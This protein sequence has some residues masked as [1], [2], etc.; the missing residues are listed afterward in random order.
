[1]RRGTTAAWAFALVGAWLASGR[2]AWTAEALSDRIEVRG[3]VTR[4]V[5]GGPVRS[6]AVEIRWPAH[7]DQFE[8][9][10]GELAPDGSYRMSVAK[11][12][13]A[14]KEHKLTVSAI[15]D[16]FTVAEK[17]LLDGRP[18]AGA[19][20]VIDFELSAATVDGV[21]DIF[22]CCVLNWSIVV[23][24]IPAFL[25]GAAVKT[26]I[27]SHRF[28]RCLGPQAPK[29]LAYGA[30][31][32]SG[33]VLSLCSCNV[34]P[35]FVSIWRSGAG[36]GPAFAFLYAGPA[37]NVVSM[38]F[39]CRVIGVGIGLW[40]TLSVAVM[41]VIVGLVMVRLFGSGQDRGG[42]GQADA[43]ASGPAVAPAAALTGLLL[44]LL[45]VGSVEMPW[46]PRLLVTVPFVAAAA[47][48]A[49]RWLEREYCRQWLR[50]GVGLFVRVMPILAPAVLAIGFAAQKMPLAAMRWLVGS[51]GLGA[52]GAAAL[53]GALMYFPIM[54]E[55]AF[56][57][58][59]LKV[60]GFGT[61][62]AMALLLTA[63]GL[64]LPGMVIVSREI[65]LK[66]VAAYV[67]TLVILA[68]LCGAFFG[69]SW[70]SYLCTCEYK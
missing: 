24:M 36:I 16:G 58:T 31:V 52:N 69:S 54:T 37:I 26:F 8:P 34:V 59:L 67:G 41:S 21:L 5:I 65:G 25:L 20:I 7:D 68:T 27:P 46:R 35:L 55:T 56:A 44:V 51:N 30:A 32:G 3:A 43:I 70:G 57:K 62:P 18:E 49:W 64:S 28:L 60:L 1:V 53:G 17:P 42:A 4:A 12:Y 48:V 29:P 10:R 9:I 15:A 45:I 22:A 14:G 61:G 38:V 66:K 2:A 11:R 13:L 39:A 6:G 23:V 33:M 19:P 40:R 63:P 47:I 50:E